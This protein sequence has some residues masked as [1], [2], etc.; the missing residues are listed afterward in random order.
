MND[1]CRTEVRKALMKALEVAEAVAR[2]ESVPRININKNVTGSGGS[3]W[4]FAHLRP[5][6]DLIASRIRFQID[7]LDLR[8]DHDDNV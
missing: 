5:D 8:S 7:C 3:G 4:T 6:A 1:C 2:G